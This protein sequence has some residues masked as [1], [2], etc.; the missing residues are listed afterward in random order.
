PALATYSLLPI[1][2]A[3]TISS[4][5]HVETQDISLAA[6]ILAGFP[7][8]LNEEQQVSDALTAL[9]ELALKP[10]ANIIK[11]PNISASV[12]Q[13][14]AAIKELQAKGYALPE[15]PDDPKDE[16]EKEIKAR[17]DKVKGSAV[18][19]VLREGNSDRRA[20]KAVKNYA[21][22]HPHSMGAWS[23]DSKSHVATMDSG[24]FAHNEKS[25]TVA[26]ETDVKISFTDRSGNVTVLKEKTHLLAGEIIDA[27]VM[28][29]KVLL[30]FLH[31]QIADAK[32]K[33]V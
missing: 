28:S 25:V 22:K 26:D 5:I 33:G 9:G 23:P 7:D 20:P 14:K 21:K 8:F 6:R 29:K 24:D 3:F 16:K 13:L 31:E 10:E 30:Q 17:Y 19:P 18:N 32:E 12:P 1:V 11:L 4:G 2:Q 15:Y 27:T